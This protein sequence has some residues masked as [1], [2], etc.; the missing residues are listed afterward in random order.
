MIVCVLIPIINV[1]SGTAFSQQIGFKNIFCSFALNELGKEEHCGC[2]GLE[3]LLKAGRAGCHKLL[4]FQHL[5][6][7]SLRL[8]INF[9]L[10]F[11][12]EI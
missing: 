7:S 12:L 11:V 1:F 6:D 3:T 5:S 4:D 2:M 9:C 8:L 10:K